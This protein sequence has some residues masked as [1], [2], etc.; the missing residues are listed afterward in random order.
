[1]TT[2]FKMLYSVLT[3]QTES[4]LQTG[5]IEKR[6]QRAEGLARLSEKIKAMSDAMAAVASSPLNFTKPKELGALMTDLRL[7]AERVNRKRRL[8]E[9]GMVTICIAGME[10]SG[11]S[12]MLK[13]LTGIDLPTAQERCTS[14]SS[15]ILYT[16]AENG[17]FDVEYYSKEELYN[18][19]A[20][21]WGYLHDAPADAWQGN[22]LSL[23]E[24]TPA[25]LEA[26]L[27]SRIPNRDALDP[28][29]ILSYESALV[30]L[31]AIQ[32]CLY[33][34]G[35]KLGRRDD[36]KPLSEL[37]HFISHKTKTSGNVSE[38]QCLIRKV[39][40]H[41]KFENGCAALRLCD[42]P[43][44][45]DP[46]RNARHLTYRTIM[47]EADILVVAHRPDNRPDPTVS[48]ARFISDLKKA[49][50][51]APLRERTVYFVNWN[52]GSDPDHSAA[53]IH[54]EKMS[55]YNIFRRIYGPCDVM[56]EGAVADF[57]KELNGFIATHLPEQDDNLISSL[58]QEF[59]SL[60]SRVRLN[61]FDDLSRQSPPLPSAIEQQMN[62]KYEDWFQDTFFRKLVDGLGRLAESFNLP[63]LSAVH[64]QI[65]NILQVTN[66]EMLG[67]IKENADE[68]ICEQYSRQG[69]DP[70]K[71]IMPK[72]AKEMTDRITKLT[73]TVETLSPAIQTQVLQ[74]IIDAMGA[75]TASALLPGTSDR[76]RLN[77]L[78]AKLAESADNQRDSDDSVRKIAEGLKE[79]AT[80][81]AAMGYV[82]RYEMRPC[83]NLLDLLR[84]S[85]ARRQ[86]MVKRCKSLLDSTEQ[87]TQ[88]SAWL[89]RARFPSFGDTAE[90]Q[91]QFLRFV[92][93]TSLQLLHCVL[94][95]HASQLQMMVDDFL[96]QASQTLATQAHCEKGWK[97]GLALYKSTILAQDAASL[98]SAAKEAEDFRN[99]LTI[100]ANSLN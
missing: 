15:D 55:K 37:H 43:G 54:I 53:D 36:R 98:L 23:T 49:D 76:D 57:L 9:N 38:E 78:Q 48:L 31:R 8:F 81:N 40:I 83:L 89:G 51:D 20:S 25:D 94:G 100:L 41:S 96:S 63:E 66:E 92:T 21:L 13:Q 93:G 68:E 86:Q 65:Q 47:E 2:A 28:Q 87:G 10:K 27:S 97:R 99:L 56:K 3:M 80:L 71:E 45:D 44:V 24:D 64:D 33:S 90:E 6:Q 46:N 72:L 75:E 88:A 14:V 22:K 19:M 34:S 32:T 30:Q 95:A 50:R 59:K 74:V 4:M 1:M 11:K 79:F 12:T 5:I 52:K 39:T 70:V 58:E 17:W 42:T 62:N 77:A 7:F 16:E 35:D 60:Q 82:M 69:K 67:W 84:W 26:F 85:A 18:V 61:I 29:S 91:A 73:Q